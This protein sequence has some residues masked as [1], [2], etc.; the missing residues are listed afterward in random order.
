MAQADI[1]WPAEVEQRT[2]ELFSIHQ[3]SLREHIFG[4]I[5]DRAETDDIVQDTFVRLMRQLRSG[6]AIAN[7]Q[8]WLFT[9]GR[10][11]ATDHIRH[12][13]HYARL[14]DLKADPLRIGADPA[15]SAEQCCLEAERAARIRYALKRLSPMEARCMELRSSGLLYREIADLLEV[16]ISTVESALAR[17]I[18]KIMTET[19]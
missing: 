17:A 2:T 12:R 8:A 19:R 15:P 4:I 13:S 5:R 7:V 18:R 14:E 9:V 16:R 6:V 1:T 11:L 10:N 3:L